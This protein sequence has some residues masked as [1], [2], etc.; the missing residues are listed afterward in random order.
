MKPKIILCLALVLSGGLFGCSSI[1]QS[2]NVADIKI[3]FANPPVAPSFDTLPREALS[4]PHDWIKHG[5]FTNVVAGHI[6]ALNV[7]WVDSKHFKN[8]EQTKNFLKE[9]LSSTNT[10][11]GNF[12]MWSWVDGVPNVTVTVEHTTGKK[13]RWMIWFSPA[14]YWAYQDDNGKW[15]WGMWD[16]LK[17]QK[18]KSLNTP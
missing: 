3:T 1:A 18:P 17:S 15:W 4:L 5:A 9:L 8:E 13:G 6:A 12:H 7:T 16:S 11:T 10:P 14:I 2:V